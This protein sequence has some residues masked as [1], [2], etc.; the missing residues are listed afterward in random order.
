[1][2][3]NMTKNNRRG[4]ET[5]SNVRRGSHQRVSTVRRGDVGRV[6]LE[7]IHLDR[8]IKNSWKK[9]CMHNLNTLKDRSDTPSQLMRVFLATQLQLFNMAVAAERVPSPVSPRH[10]HS[11]GD[12]GKRKRRKK[13]KMAGIFLQYGGHYFQ[14]GHH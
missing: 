3:L 2:I 10:R 6:D 9:N 4:F 5:S 1:M 14:N 13:S 7:E 8:V 11:G 12:R